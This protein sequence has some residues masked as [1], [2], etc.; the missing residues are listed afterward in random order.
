MSTSSH[1]YRWRNSY[2][3][4][5]EISQNTLYI[6]QCTIVRRQESYMLLQTAQKYHFR[7]IVP[8]SRLHQ[9]LH[10]LFLAPI[11]YAKTKLTPKLCCF[12]K[13]VQKI[14]KEIKPHKK[15]ANHFESDV[16]ITSAG[17]VRTGYTELLSIP[18][19]YAE[20][21]TQHAP[22]IGMISALLSQTIV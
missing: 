15:V 5:W 19:L 21:F 20:S 17:N 12:N 13:E 4:S 14:F 6:C 22:S 10:H 11:K 18:F 16:W 7:R 3:W 2:T 8:V 9:F 1:Y